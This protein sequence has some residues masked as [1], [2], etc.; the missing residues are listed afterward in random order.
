VEFNPDGSP[1]LAR[2]IPSVTKKKRMKNL[3]QYQDMPDEEFDNIMEEKELNI[4][5]SQDFEKQIEKRL[6]E[7]EQDYDLNDLKI[8]DKATLRALVQAVISLEDYEQY[9]NNLRG[10]GISSENVYIFEKVNKVMSEL[11]RDISDFQDDL[12]ITRK[13]RKSDT[14][15]SVI[16]YI[17][18]LKE[19]AKKFLESKQR[20]IFCSKCRT[21]L[22]TYWSLYPVSKN[23]IA[24]TC[25]RSLDGVPCGNVE[26]FT[27]KE[28]EENRGSNHPEFMPEKMI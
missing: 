16:A 25:G 26:K 5:K 27:T 28:V 17:D 3:I 13:Q 23:V 18:N 20:Y 1:K 19:K 11:R 8:N 6:S 2:Q 14:E 15:Q 12:K 21:L 4:V 9:L 7:F 24:L 10:A 22:F